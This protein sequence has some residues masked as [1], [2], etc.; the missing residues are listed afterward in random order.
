MTAAAVSGE[1]QV[2]LETASQIGQG[3]C[4]RAIWHG[5]RCNWIGVS[6]EEGGYG[7]L[8]TSYAALAPDLYGGT[9][10]VAMFLAQLHAAS[11]DV[12]ARRTALGAIRQ[13]LSRVDDLP[14]E[15]GAGVYGGRM[16]VAVAAARVGVLLDEPQLLKQAT[17][18][19]CSLHPVGDEFDLIS[20]RAGGIVGLL[21]LG[22]L[23]GGVQF[24]DQAAQFGDRLLESGQRSDNRCS[25]KSPSISSRRN[26]TGFSHGTAGAGYALL[27]LFRMTGL[28][29]YRVG[30][31]QAFNYERHLFDRHAQN[32]PDFRERRIRRGRGPAPLNSPVSFATFWCHGAPGIGLSRLRAY[33]LLRDTGCETEAMA[34]VTTTSGTMTAERANGGLANYSLCH[35][36]AGN[37]EVLLQA[38]RTLGSRVSNAR[39]LALEVASAGIDSY[40]APGRAWPCGTREGEPPGL[41]L[42]LA[43][44]G[45]F[46]LRLYDPGI[47]SLLLLKPEEFSLSQ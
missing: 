12:A 41:F 30:A 26:L 19:G 46:Y 24:L 20:G 31:E 7:Q 43:G 18:L 35:G 36:I 29:E 1:T 3:L 47:P 25:W 9:S 6:T 10:G 13:A 38:A 45:L 32:W 14:H 17:A 5:E 27:E 15:T 40:A 34:A 23:L 4:G 21:V 28:E 37:A 42:G 22:E 8:V 44:I 16:G 33:E 11:G 39:D 2:F